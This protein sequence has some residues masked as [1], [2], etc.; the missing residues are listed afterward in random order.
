MAD[1]QCIA[2]APRD[3]TTVDLWVRQRDD[4]RKGH[5]RFC[6]FR[7]C[8]THKTWRAVGDTHFV[9]S[10]PEFFEITHFRIPAPPPEFQHRVDVLNRLDRLTWSIVMRRVAKYQARSKA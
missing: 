1:W 7:W 2:L 3:G 4:H 9:N 6:D 10:V 5:R 8:D